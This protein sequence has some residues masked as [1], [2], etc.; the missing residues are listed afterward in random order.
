M[1][2]AFIIN[3][4]APDPTEQAQKLT[5]FLIG[6]ELHTENGT[7]II[8]Y[9]PENTD[10]AALE[11]ISA[12]LPA[13]R[14]FCASSEE[15]LP[16]NVLPFLEETLTDTDCILFPGNYFGEELSIRL[17]ARLCGTS[18]SDVQELHLEENKAVARKKIYSGHLIGTFE[19]HRKPYVIAIPK[20]YSASSETPCGAK[21]ELIF[22]ELKASAQKPSITKH[23]I[24]KESFL[25]D[26]RCIVVGGRG[27]KN[28]ENT[29]AV[30]R[31]AET[32]SAPLAGSRPAVMNA[33][34]PMNRL[35]GVSGTMILPKLCILLGVS[36][37]PAL[38]SGIEKSKYIIALNH[39]KDAP[40]MKK[41]DLA[42]CGDCMELFQM[43]TK[44][45]Q[46]K[47]HEN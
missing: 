7:G 8:L 38:Y 21:K 11:N 12:L 17:A 27:L 16:E 42:I 28:K 32:I 1:K 36:G 41:A 26:A 4:F 10:T 40:I 37:A 31:L 39:D 23:P 46:E 22:L 20:N 13:S 9:D 24:E 45:V 29:E 34:L 33:W 47:Q 3:A 30:S 18:L 35:I 5:Q 15:Y 19:L 43:F 6:N 44:I 2:Y 25:E 14:I